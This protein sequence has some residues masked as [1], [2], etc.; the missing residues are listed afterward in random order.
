MKLKVVVHAAEEGGYWAEMPAIPGC[1]SQGETMDELEQNLREAIGA[2]IKLDVSTEPE[3]LRPEPEFFRYFGSIKVGRDS[4][5]DPSGQQE[6]CAAGRLRTRSPANAQRFD[7]R[8]HVQNFTFRAV[9]DS[10][11]R[12]ILTIVLDTK[13][14]IA[15]LTD[16]DPVQ[17][18][19]AERF[20]RKA[21]T[22]SS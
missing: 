15:A 2:C 12:A 6:G 4:V 9:P 20:I 16:R 17:Q 13:L 3:A 7:S 8:D 14:I 18:Q 19:A 21:L 5:I 10:R 22:R 11:L 1:A